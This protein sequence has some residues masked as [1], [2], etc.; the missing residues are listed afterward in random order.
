MRK[1]K[2]IVNNVI[3]TP[4]IVTGSSGFIG[5]NLTRELVNQGYEVNLFLREESKTWRLDD[6]IRDT[7]IHL[8]D[9]T[10]EKEVEIA[11]KKIKP[12]TIFHLAAYGAYP[13][14][15]KCQKN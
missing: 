12:K 4:I 13:Y 7:I 5:A 3:N 8:V 11:V 14:Q 1:F 15:K 6:I 10:S 9:L 2:K